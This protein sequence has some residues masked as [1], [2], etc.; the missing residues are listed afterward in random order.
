MVASSYATISPN[1]R[2]I[3]LHTTHNT[4]KNG[5][6]H[7]RRLPHKRIMDVVVMC[8]LLDAEMHCL[9]GRGMVWAGWCACAWSS[10][11]TLWV[12]QCERMAQM[13]AQFVLQPKST[14]MVTL[15]SILIGFCSGSPK[16][17]FQ[18]QKTIVC[19]RYTTTTAVT[20]IPKMWTSCN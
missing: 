18:I 15:L 13:I 2:H 1:S 9:R 6:N 5:K 16:F 12:T 4:T 14:Q 7:S 3:I 19:A 10:E 20:N 11:F 8:I 17:F